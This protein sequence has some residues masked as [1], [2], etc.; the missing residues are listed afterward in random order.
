MTSLVAW[1]WQGILLAALIE[2][3]LRAFPRLNAATRH[4]VWWAA[5]GGLFALPFAPVAARL[6]AAPAAPVT[7]AS[8]L[9]V[10]SGAV[11]SLPAMPGWA[12]VLVVAAWA[13]IAGRGIVRTARGIRNVGALRQR[14]RPLDDIRAARLARWAS[15]RRRRAALLCVT[16]ASIG[17]CAVGF[18]RPAILV[19]S[20][21]L[22]AV[23]DDVLEQ[24]VL[25]EQAHLD[26]YDDWSR[27]LQKVLSAIGAV[28]PAVHLI[29]RRID[30]EREVA[31]DD[32][33]VSITG[34]PID[35]AACLAEAAAATSGVPVLVPSAVGMSA[36]NGRN[37]RARVVRL[38]DARHQGD[39]R[40][41]K[42]VVAGAA[43]SIATILSVAP[44]LPSLVVFVERAAPPA[45]LATAR[46]LASRPAATR[47]RS[48]VD[49]LSGVAAGSPASRAAAAASLDAVVAG[50]QGDRVVENATARP[51]SAEPDAQTP[52][53]AAYDDAVET[54]PDGVRDVPVETLHA[55]GVVVVEAP[56]V[57]ERAAAPAVAPP[58]AIADASFFG[59]VSRFGRSSA[60]TA[61][62]AGVSVAG[63]FARAGK[64]IGKVF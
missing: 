31:C 56:P 27:L 9:M 50:G 42:P 15:G 45:P 29:N 10:E 13:G 2:L 36:A 49:P 8:R 53:A 63:T 46:V 3:L 23:T 41:V 57:H 52:A 55:L 62:R 47:L 21:L 44:V 51:A 5:L 17:A 43:A 38:L 4:V 37:L 28:H 60:A 40:V 48:V 26:R 30:L 20:D 19:S 7:S 35:Y 24:I 6:V 39:G 18:R 11:V 61:R 12:L 64:A 16:D 33:V 58:A 59:G 25:H 32:R 1:L 54:L 14:A 34:A 22:D